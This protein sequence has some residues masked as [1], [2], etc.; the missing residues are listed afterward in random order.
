MS[1]LSHFL[2]NKIWSFSFAFRPRSIHLRGSLHYRKPR[3]FA[4]CGMSS[5][6]HHPQV[7][8]IARSSSICKMLCSTSLHLHQ[9]TTCT[10]QCRLLGVSKRRQ[11]LFDGGTFI[12]FKAI[13]D[14]NVS[15]TP[16]DSVKIVEVKA[17]PHNPCASDA[18]S[19]FSSDYLNSTQACW[20]K[21]RRIWVI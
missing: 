10:T 17:I 15:S 8:V 5:T 16:L 12:L 13:I 20:R 7:P 19:R 21:S 18:P 2:E 1:I 4:L 3:I 6:L 14:I 11:L 9:C